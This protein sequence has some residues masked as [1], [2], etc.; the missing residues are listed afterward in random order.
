MAA[1]R[2][3][4][5]LTL[6]PNAIG[7]EKYV[8]RYND[9]HSKFVHA[10]WLLLEDRGRTVVLPDAD[11]SDETYEIYGVWT[12]DG[13]RVK[14]ML[15]SLRGG[16]F[17]LE[18]SKIVSAALGYSRMRNAVTGAEY[19]W[20]YVPSNRVGKMVTETVYAELQKPAVQFRDDDAYTDD[21]TQD[22]YVDPLVKALQ[23]DIT[24]GND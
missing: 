22:F 13:S 9:Q 3:I 17:L 6:N 7:I 19:N 4:K 14:I 11:G 23:D 12:V 5:Y 21:D 8:Q 18:D 16:P 1:R 10:S 15:K 2:F 24:D 20:D